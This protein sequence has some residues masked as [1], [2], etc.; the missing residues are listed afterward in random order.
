[1]GGGHELPQLGH[2]FVFSAT[3]F[4]TPRSLPGDKA[5]WKVIDVHPERVHQVAVDLPLP[6]DVDT[7]EDYLGACRE[8]RVDPGRPAGTGRS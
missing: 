5:V 6:V 2:P 8:L 3:A 7:W 1:M 4:G